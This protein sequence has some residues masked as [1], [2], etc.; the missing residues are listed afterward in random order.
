MSSPVWPLCF[1]Y[2]GPVLGNGFIAHI[3]LTGRLLAILETDGVWLNGITPAAMAVT[4]Q[5]L[6]AASPIHRDALTKIFIDFAQESKTFEE[7]EAQVKEFFWA[8]DDEIN[9]WKSAVGRIE[10]GQETIPEGL[11]R[12]PDPEIGIKVIRRSMEQLT[13]ADNPLIHRETQQLFA[14]AEPNKAA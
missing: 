1:K 4:A 2:T 5:T 13:P 10:S 6:E 9:D 7:F 11:K 3:E 14:A 8:E 12:C